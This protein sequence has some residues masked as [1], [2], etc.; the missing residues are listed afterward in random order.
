[1]QHGQLTAHKISF[2][3]TYQATHGTQRN[4]RCGSSRRLSMR[5]SVMAVMDGD[6]SWEE[7]RLDGKVGGVFARVSRRGSM[8]S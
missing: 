1:M 6:N 8:R 5:G 2:S 7:L 4:G 3:V